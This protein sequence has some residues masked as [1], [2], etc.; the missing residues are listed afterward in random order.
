MAETYVTLSSLKH[1][2]EKIK[3]VIDC[4]THKKKALSAVLLLKFN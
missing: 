3:E 4:S 2:D 1:Y